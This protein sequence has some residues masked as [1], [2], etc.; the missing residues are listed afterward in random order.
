V[1][2]TSMESDSTSSPAAP[3]PTSSFAVAIARLDQVIMSLLA[4]RERLLEYSLPPEMETSGRRSFLDPFSLPFAVDNPVVV[5]PY[6]KLTTGLWIG[7][8]AASTASV[9]VR[10]TAKTDPFVS[11]PDHHF[12]L[13]IDVADCGDS[14]WL[15]LE[16]EV[17]RLPFSQDYVVTVAF[18][19][20]ASTSDSIAFELSVP[21]RGGSDVRIPLGSIEL[22]TSFRFA[23]LSAR[24][25]RDTFADVDRSKSLRLIGFLPTRAG[26]ALE[27]AFLR[28]LLSAGH[29]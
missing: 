15:T 24:V 21:R 12:L 9:S 19:G 29:F 27:I 23:S 13:Q 3:E 25:A 1:L 10:Q 6:Q 14:K 7:F 11:P 5:K 18:K 17:G 8:E 20:R 26:Y 16:M 2:P 28:T 22:D 4:E